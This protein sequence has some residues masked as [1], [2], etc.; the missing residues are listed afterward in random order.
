MTLKLYVAF[1]QHRVLFLKHNILIYTY[2][3]VFCCYKNNVISTT[4][5]IPGNPRKPTS[6]PF[7]GFSGIATILNRFKA[8]ITIKP[9]REFVANRINPFVF[10]ANTKPSPI[11]RISPIIKDSTSSIVSILLRY[12]AILF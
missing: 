3:L 9:A 10:R 7:S 6:N 1:L 5:T 8:I 12:S 2:T 4:S 11:T